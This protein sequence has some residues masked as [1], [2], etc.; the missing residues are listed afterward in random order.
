MDFSYR[1]NINFLKCFTGIRAPLYV[2]Y[3]L[4][5]AC[6]MHCRMCNAV[7]SRQSEKELTITEIEQ[8]ADTLKKMGVGLIILT[9]GEP[10]LRED[11]AEVVRI[12]HDR[13]FS[14]RIQ[15]NGMLFSK[16][17]LEQLKISGLGGITISVHSLSA[18]K[19][20][21]ITNQPDALEKLCKS[22]YLLNEVFSSPEYILGINTVVCG[23]N[24]EEIPAI[25][26]FATRVGFS[27]SLIPVHLNRGDQFIV[28]GKDRDFAISKKD[29]PAVDRLY[30]ELISLK[31]GGYNIYNSERFL[32]ESPAF[33]KSGK[34][35]WKCES[36]DLYFS[37]SPSGI[38]LPCV[39]LEGSYSML[40]PGFLS[41]WETEAFT[42][43]IR[44]RVSK[45]SGCM[46]AC[47]PEF[48]YMLHSKSHFIRRVFEY[49]KMSGSKP[50]EL[51]LDAI[52]DLLQ[53]YAT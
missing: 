52:H 2:Q 40:D 28:R 7:Q 15:S 34:V 1:Q 16:N 30:D 11:I 4:S 38:F 50:R 37:I 5:G 3:A 43:E 20:A 12:F 27:I 45:C 17:L 44:E 33:L 19:M 26:K 25:V 29:Y 22:I 32:R 39:D 23:L 21:Y 48:S 51:T 13:K 53:E 14:V 46:Y 8:L 42:D 36:P 49:R 10:L 31:R 18:E 24:I 47:Y 35:S 41:L 9:G 6:N